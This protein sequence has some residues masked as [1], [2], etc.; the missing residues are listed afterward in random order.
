MKVTVVPVQVGLLS[1]E[2]RTVGVT[3]VVTLI[4]ITFDVAVVVEAHGAFEVNIHVIT[5][6]FAIDDGVNVELFVPAFIPFTCH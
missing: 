2:I 6:L 3:F 1:T 4:V 5:S